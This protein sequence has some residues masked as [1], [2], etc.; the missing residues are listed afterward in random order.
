MEQPGS[1][2]HIDI[3]FGFY[4]ITHPNSAFISTIH[5]GHAN[6][7]QLSTGMV[8]GIIQGTERTFSF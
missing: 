4:K 2:L 5:I 8:P 3:E 7:E 6:E 1:N